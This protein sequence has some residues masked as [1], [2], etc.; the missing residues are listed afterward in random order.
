[1]NGSRSEAPYPLD[2]NTAARFWRKT[3]RA[4]NGCVT[5]LG[6]KTTDGYGRFLHGKQVP[7]HRVAYQDKHGSIEAGLTLDHLCKNPGCVNPDHLEPVTVRVNT[8]RGQSP[9]IAAELFSKDFCVRGH[10]MPEFVPGRRQRVCLPCRR[11]LHAERMRD[12][13]AK[14]KR[15]EQQ[16][17]YRESRRSDPDFRAKAAEAQRQ[18]RKRRRSNES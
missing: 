15:I 8:L 4:G 3:Q 13:E 17:R 14:A 16:R 6:G 12:P 9:R 7:A 5:W 2:G 10:A 18:Y 1:M 11:I